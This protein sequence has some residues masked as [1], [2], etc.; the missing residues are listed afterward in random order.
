MQCFKGCINTSAAGGTASC[1][2][3]RAASTRVQ[4]VKQ[5]HA[6]LQ[7]LHQHECSRWNSIMQCFKSCINTSAAGGTASCNASR[8]E[9]TRVQ[10]VKQHHAMLQELHQHE[11]SRWNNIMQC[12]KSCI[13]TSAA[14]GTASCNASR[15][16]STRVQQVKQ[17]HA[18]LQELHQHECS[19]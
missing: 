6:M 10:Q 17:H 13:N 1:N 3:S 14:G 7:E 4:Q 19:R 9:S 18:M 16:A 15:A 8:A 2:A 11:C 12:F 5:H